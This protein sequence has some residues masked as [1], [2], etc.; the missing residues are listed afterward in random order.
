MDDVIFFFGGWAPI[1]RVVVVGTLAYV[2]LVLL[3]RV[4][5]KRILTRMN[6]FDLLIAVSMGAV[7]GRVL[8]AQNVAL[9]EAVAAFALLATLQSAMAWLQFRFP[10]FAA[11]ATPSPTLPYFRQRVLHD[12]LRRERVTEPE[13]RTAAR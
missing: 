5:G 6:G 2:A 12:A 13:L 10:K 1:A 4:S 7:F 11:V 8:T 3:M 9:A